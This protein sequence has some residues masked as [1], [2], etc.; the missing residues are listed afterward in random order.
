[1]PASGGRLGWDFFVS[2]TSADQAWAEWIAWQLEN[3]GYRVLIQA[4]DFVPGAHWMT[5]MA[6]GVRTSQRVPA[7]LSEASLSS[8][9]GH[10]EWETAFQQDPGG[11]PQTL[12]TAHNLAVALNELGDHQ[13]A[14]DL[15]QDTLT[16]Q[17]QTLGNDHS[18]AQ[19]TG[20]ML[21]RIDRQRER[22]R[23]RSRWLGRQP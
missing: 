17:R 16:R 22:G 2:Y 7:V 1:M 5:R 3:A 4:W 12:T 10:K 11:H 9:Y 15:A 14:R 6:E 19:A 21:S 8:V 18:A 23:H 20:Q 13:A